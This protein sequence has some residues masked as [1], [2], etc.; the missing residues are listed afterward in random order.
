MTHASK[1]N[2]DC[3][4]DLIIQRPNVNSAIER[5]WA[6]LG[7]C[8]LNQKGTFKVTIHHLDEMPIARGYI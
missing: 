8:P 4:L 6:E 7:S 5:S 3:F 1:Y 2:Q